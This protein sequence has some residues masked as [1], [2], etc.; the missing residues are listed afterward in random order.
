M[1]QTSQPIS[2]Y[3]TRMYYGLVDPFRLPTT[4]L[5]RA[6]DVLRDHNTTPRTHTR[7]HTQTHT[8]TQYIYISFY[9]C[10]L[11]SR[12]L[13]TNHDTYAYTSGA[14]NVRSPGFYLARGRA[15]SLA[16]RQ[17]EKTVIVIVECAPATRKVSR[18]CVC[19]LF[20]SSTI[21]C[22]C[23]AFTSRAFYKRASPQ[24]TICT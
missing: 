13:F 17:R 20:L 10:A 8:N 2:T 11:D 15:H 22:I 7:I 19:V 16:K 12:G 3:T 24:Y 6:S 21:E 4:H 5:L 1:P 23:C 9:V 14:A 18:W